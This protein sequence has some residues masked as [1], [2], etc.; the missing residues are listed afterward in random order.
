[1]FIFA[2]ETAI[3]GHPPRRNKNRLS[4]NSGERCGYVSYWTV[5]G[6]L[7]IVWSYLH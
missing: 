7:S 1:M 6:T 3:S 2:G 5:K 4:A